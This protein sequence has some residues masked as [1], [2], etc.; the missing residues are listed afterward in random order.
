M[1]CQKDIKHSL[2]TK[3]DNWHKR[4]IR[5]SVKIALNKRSLNQEE[6]LHL[7][8]VWLLLYEWLTGE[9]KVNQIDRSQQIV[10]ESRA[11]CAQTN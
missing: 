6:G 9:N 1:S 2:E 5:E 3:V 11:A 8:K 4:I 10:G 7:R